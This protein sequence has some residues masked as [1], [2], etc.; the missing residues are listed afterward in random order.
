[1]FSLNN[2][3]IKHSAQITGA[4]LIVLISGLWILHSTAISFYLFM[5][6]C[7]VGGVSTSH[8]ILKHGLVALPN[9]IIRCDATPD[10]LYFTQRNGIRIKA[11]PMAGS[12]MSEKL[13]LLTW[14][15]NQQ[16]SRWH[17]LFTPE[18][19]VILSKDNVSS[20]EDFRR[21]RVLLTFSKP[22]KS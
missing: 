7:A 6:M 14:R 15:A 13:L 20:L 4:A 22:K 17:G 8:F 18:N 10:A 1:V 3:R 19:L 11:I 2:L 16:K 12:Y 9:S 21:L 5:G